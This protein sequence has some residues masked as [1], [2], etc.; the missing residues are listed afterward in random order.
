MPEQSREPVARA[1][2]LGG[3]KQG[4]SPRGAASQPLRYTGA[5]LLGGREVAGVRQARA[6]AVLVRR[7]EGSAARRADPAVCP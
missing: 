3:A 4:W 1:E 5:Q 2:Q 7:R 6:K